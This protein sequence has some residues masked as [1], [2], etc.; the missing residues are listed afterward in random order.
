M[1]EIARMEPFNDVES[2]AGFGDLPSALNF[3]RRL[4]LEHA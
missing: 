2:T 4:G 1:K 3:C